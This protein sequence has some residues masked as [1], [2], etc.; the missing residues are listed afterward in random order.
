MTKSPVAKVIVMDQPYQK[1][2]AWNAVGRDMRVSQIAFSVADVGRSLRWYTEVFG[3]LS[4]GMLEVRAPY[5]G[6]D[7]ILGTMQELPGAEAE[8]R[9]AVDQQEFFQLEF[10][11]YR[12]PTP[13]R[14]T[15]PRRPCD[16]GY[17]R[18]GF[19]VV[20]FDAAVSR[21]ADAKTPLLTE[22]LGPDGARR[23]AVRDP[24]GV[25]VEL[26]E[27]DLRAPAPSV[28][29]RPAVAGA[30]RS[31]TVSVGDL[32][33]SHR[34]F[35]EGLGMRPAPDAQLHEPA[36]EA[37]WGL[38]G[39]SR[40]V[41]LLW[42][43]DFWVELVEYREPRGQPRPPDA[44]FSDIGILN[45]AIGTR[46]QEVYDETVER[47]RAI[48]YHLNPPLTTPDIHCCYLLDDQGFSVE[49]MCIA[50]A[51]DAQIGFLPTT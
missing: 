40:E 30:A 11:Q 33:R 23:V 27:A 37:L 3:V 24:N 21:L 36:H 19:W 2:E 1:T 26:M 29:P 51:V 6:A 32:E 9:W 5:P 15:R 18:I 47:I 28:R 8:V 49:L 39:R 41:E 22:P 10:F 38:D 45:F 46:S 14:P 20:D 12:T 42:S 48:G 50:E 7:T 35:V 17:A 13:R 31:I 25:I 44:N 34:F 16:A 43:G 4:S